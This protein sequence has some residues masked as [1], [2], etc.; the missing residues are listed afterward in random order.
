MSN[1][2]LYRGKRIEELTH[3]ECVEC[4]RDI[5]SRVT[6]LETLMPYVDY[7]RQARDMMNANKGGKQ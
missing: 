6:V 3:E 7:R 4:I 5:L 1:V 2:I